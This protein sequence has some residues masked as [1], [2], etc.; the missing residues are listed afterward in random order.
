MTAQVRAKLG[1]PIRAAS[2]S[3]SVAAFLEAA[4]GES[5]SGNPDPRAQQTVRRLLHDILAGIYTPGARIREVE[6]AERL[7]ISRAPVREALRLLEQDGLI[8][9][10]PWRGARVVDQ[11]PDEIA[12]LFDL[13]AS[14]YGAV[15]RFTVRHATE[16]QFDQLD[17]DIATCITRS[18]EGD[19]IEQIDLAYRLG[20]HMGQ[21]CGNALAANMLRRLG[22]IAYLKHRLLQPLPARWRQQAATRMR[23][24]QAA[25]RTRS[26]DKCDRAARRV[27]QHTAKLVVRHAREA[28]RQHEA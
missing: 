8:E 25:L 1:R 16:A 11:T 7:G 10:L 15:A 28:A 24:L 3:A 4:Q 13:L 17:A 26:E 12:D 2:S 5:A 23:R 22:R 6:V 27:I 18:E 14:V 20:G 9:I 19:V 21:F